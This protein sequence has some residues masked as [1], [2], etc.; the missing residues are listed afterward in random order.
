MNTAMLSMATA[1]GF[2]RI[3]VCRRVRPHLCVGL[4]MIMLIATNA[5][6]AQTASGRSIDSID[7]TLSAQVQDAINHGVALSINS[8]FAIRESWW[9]VKTSAKPRNHRFMIQRHALSNRYIVK[10]D[11]LDTPH[12]F[13]TIPEATN[14]IAAQSVMLLEFYHDTDNPYSMR[15]SLNKFDLPG[16]MRLNAFLSSDWEMDT[17]WVSR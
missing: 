13:I 17:G 8:A 11:D 15:V 10:R 6:S 14:Y 12:I 2:N 7:I 5:V 16:P 4:L 3:R 1:F 9:F